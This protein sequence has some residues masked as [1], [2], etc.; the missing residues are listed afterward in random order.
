MTVQRNMHVTNNDTMDERAREA[1]RE[2]QRTYYAKNKQ[3]VKGWQRDY[4]A[5]RA[6]KEEKEISED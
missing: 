4:W 3:K 2:Y 6:E 1:R 5:R